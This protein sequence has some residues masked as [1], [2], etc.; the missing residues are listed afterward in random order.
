MDTLKILATIFAVGGSLLLGIGGYVLYTQSAAMQGAV[1]VD[2]T[3][4]TATLEGKAGS[5]FAPSVVYRYEYDGETYEN[6]DLYP[7]VVTQETSGD[8]AFEISSKYG[9]DAEITAYVD[10]NDPSEAYL[11]EKLATRMIIGFLGGG[12]FLV[13]LAAITATWNSRRDRLEGWLERTFGGVE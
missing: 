4:E 10:P 2:A 1:A 9:Q 3:V 12:V 8:R 13:G 6:D 5:K 7:G 11:I